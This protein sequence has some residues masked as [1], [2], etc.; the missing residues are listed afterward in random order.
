MEKRIINSYPATIWSDCTPV[1]NGVLGASVYGCVYDERILINHEALYN[2]TCDVG[3]PDIS[4]ALKEVRALMDEGKYKEA[5]TYYTGI[6]KKTG[7][8]SNK[9]KF[10]PAFDI[11]MIFETQAAPENYRRELDME[12]GICTVSYTENGEQCTRTVFASQREKTILVNLKKSAPFSVKISLE[13]HDMSDYVD[14]FYCDEFK[15]FAK[16]GYV[17]SESKTGGKLH[18]SGVVKVLN[19]DGAMVSGGNDKALKIDMTGEAKLKDYIKIE[20]AK[21]VTLIFN[22]SKNVLPFEETKKLVDKCQKSYETLL[23]E[24]KQDFSKLFNSTR[25]TLTNKENQS[26]EQLFLNSYGGAVDTR[27]IEKM[28]DYGRYLLISSSVGCEYPANL[29]GL[30]NGAY[31]PAWACTFFNNENI[32]MAYWQAYAG[33]LSQATL[34]LFNL[35]DRFK[36]DYRENAKNLFGCRGILLPL[37]MDNS[38]GKKEN[39]QPHVL[40][41]TGSSAWISAIYYDY[42]LYTGDEEF[43][44]ERA[45]PFMKESALF[46]EDFMV[47]D[48]NGKLKSYP[49][50]SPENH[51]NG[52]FEGAGELS[53]SINATMDFAL[54][55]EL[56]TNLISAARQLGIDEEKSKKWAKMLSD[57]PDYEINE[58]GAIKE[59]LHPDFKDNYHH[60]HQSH[61]YP[62]FPGFEINEEN[63]K[64]L[65]EASRVAVQKRLVIGLKSQTGWS[66]AHMANIFARLNDGKGAKE[67]LDLLIRFCTGTNLYTYHNDWRNMG[68]T[69]KFLHAGHPPYQIDA[70]MGFTSAIYEM[71]LY[72]DRDKIKLLPALPSEF[73][74]GKIE[75]IHTRGGFVVT[76]EWNEASAKATIK[77]VLGGSINVGIKGYTLT[78]VSPKLSYS[79]YGEKYRLLTLSKNEE[80]TL[81]FV[82]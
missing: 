17:Y 29:Q 25:L 42:Y 24:Q 38:N 37:F 4:Y 35:Y 55:K 7:F 69:L 46:Y 5:N 60:R 61:I 44:R 20:N 81:D 47:Y 33:G 80:I 66:L 2:W 45:Y 12:T 58:D 67:C 15:S 19:T 75:N 10:F 57:I 14:N 76:I 39:T 1:G 56:L 41:W 70:N 30:W 21:E 32:Q 50:N 28:A 3:Y 40:Y 9:G 82:K 43:L 65:F 26:N 16:D 71:L 22:M 51:P 59:W 48:S 11:H 18:F 54:L 79:E 31:S 52:D 68:V 77:S 49:S 8:K 27:I 36:D 64:E 62:L 78:T 72:S 74:E 73:N 53:V 23:N 13:R 63:N 6:I 34:P